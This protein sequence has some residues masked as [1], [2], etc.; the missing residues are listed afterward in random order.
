MKKLTSLAALASLLVPMQGAIAQE[1]R[2]VTIVTASAAPSV[3]SCQVQTGPTA[4]IIK[5]NVVEALTEV[6]VVNG[7]VTPLLSTEWSRPSEDTWQF[8]LREGV[9]FHDGTP[10]NAEAVIHSIERALSEALGCDAR[11]RYF[12]NIEVKVSAVDD[13]TIDIT[14]TPPQPILPTLMESIPIVPLSTSMTELTRQP[15]GT[16][17]YVFTKW[18]TQSEILLD[19]FGEYWGAQPQVEEAR[20]IW[21]EDSFVRAS[22]VALGEADLALGI[23]DQ[24]ADNPQTDVSFYNA[25]MMRI[26][27]NTDQAPLND[28]RVRKALNL[29]LDREGLVG[30][31]QNEKVRPSSQIVGPSALGHDPDLEPFPYDPA[32]AQALVEEARADGVPVDREI[33]MLT[34][35]GVMPNADETIQAFI[36]MWSAIGLNVKVNVVEMGQFRAAGRPPYDTNRPPTMRLASHDNATGDAGVSLLQKYHSSS[37]Q[38]D[39]P[40]AEIDA[41]IDAGL[42][43]EGDE[44]RGKFQQVL[45]F[46]H[47]E[48]VPEVWLYDM[49]SIFRVGPR[50]N[51]VANAASAAVIEISTITFN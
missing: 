45:R 26:Q 35:S 24:H 44:R 18:D 11:N 2:T 1:N 4:R 13:H 27:I 14:T 51:Y 37:Y 8:K 34:Y 32:Q 38:V 42:A 30:V 40:N 12:A 28:L 46:E 6:D 33:N 15:V 49:V 39:L 21:R 41:L 43:A 16:G 19:R 17:P 29:A 50:I 31:L 9:V 36:E 25:E 48:I 7:G 23:S 20:Y 47:E 10:M 5:M 22:M 3:D